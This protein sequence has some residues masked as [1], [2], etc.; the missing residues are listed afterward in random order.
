MINYVFDVDGTLTPSR[1]TIDK[2]FRDFFVEFIKQNNVY[3][4]TGSDHSKTVEQ[5]GTI[6][7]ETVN[8]VYNCSGNSIWKQGKEIYRSDWALPQQAKTFLSL[9]LQDS[10]F[11]FRSGRHI[12]ERPGL[13]NFSVVG[14]NCTLGE[15]K[16]YVKYDNDFFER[17]TI[18]ELF[19]KRFKDLGIVAQV[20]GETGIDIM[21][22]GCDKGQIVK[23]IQQPIHFFGDKMQKGGNDYPLR[24]I[25]GANSTWSEVKNW[26]QTFKILKKLCTFQEK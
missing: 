15:R 18:A 9:M 4:V 19:N 12:E 26:E 20:A 11:P 22:V 24:A 1:G 13:V 16:M 8:K 25:L 10:E 3:L 23:H 21:K 5:L 7:T 6:I 14:R 2:S 17:E